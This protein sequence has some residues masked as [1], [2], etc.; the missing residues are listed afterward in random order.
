MVAPRQHQT[1]AVVA[2]EPAPVERVAPSFW[3]G[4]RTAGFLLV[5]VGAAAAAGGAVFGIQAI[6]QKQESDAQCAT[7]LG[8]LRCNQAGVD[9]MSQARTSAW[10][11]DG[12]IGLAVVGI[13]LGSFLFFT[14]GAHE[15]GAHE[16]QASANGGWTWQASAGPKSA[17]GWLT[18]TF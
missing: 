5:V 12:L 10:V 18:R 1:L 3:T 7:L 9:D 15:G 16:R 13:G 17:T 4:K 2:L 6:H 14:G 8:D 11:S